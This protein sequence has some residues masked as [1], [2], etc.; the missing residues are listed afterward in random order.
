MCLRRSSVPRSP[1]VRNS[2]SAQGGFS[3]IELLVV[4]F[5]IALLLG[6]LLPVLPKARDAGKRVA[7]ASNLRNVG[8]V[9]EMYKNDFK[10][11]F[12]AARYMPPPWLSGDPDPPLNTVLSKYIDPDSG[13]S[14]V[15]KCPGDK[16]VFDMPYK[17]RD[18]QLKKCGMSY[19][20]MVSLSGQ[21]YE[22]TFYFTFLKKSPSDTPVSYDFDGGTFET[23]VEGEAV[24]VNYF[25]AA[26]NVLF[27]DGHVGKYGKRAG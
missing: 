22:K 8:Q 26:R 10:E 20:Y 9:V 16:I 1:T 4:M 3:L 11:V 15:Y 25:H 19:T 21:P 5:I 18:G 13:E 14:R 2:P 23:Q 7:C 17:T 27:V 12:P 6:I 24:T